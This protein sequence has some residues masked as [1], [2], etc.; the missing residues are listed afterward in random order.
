MLMGSAPSQ[1]ELLDR[2]TPQVSP[3]RSVPTAGPG[4]QPGPA[5]AAAA[6][7]LEAQW[8]RHG[9]SVYALACALLGDSAAAIR[10]VA[11]AMTDLTHATD[12]VSD[13]EVRRSLARQVYRHS[14]HVVGSTPTW[15]GLPPAMVWLRDM[16]QLQRACLALCVFGGLTHREAASLLGVPPVKVAELLTQGLKDLNRAAAAGTS[17]TPR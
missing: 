12:T 8:A 17:P 6:L 7:P 3:V 10:V 13:Q 2:A 16:A 1:I 9:N 11:L 15:L 4:V 14:Q 5:S